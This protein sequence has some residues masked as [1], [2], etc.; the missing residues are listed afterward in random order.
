MVQ[1]SEYVL[2]KIKRLLIEKKSLIII[3]EN[4]GELK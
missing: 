2:K 4:L 1:I 3:Y